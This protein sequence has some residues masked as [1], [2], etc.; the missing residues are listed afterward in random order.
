MITDAAAVPKNGILIG[1]DEYIEKII[2]SPIGV[3][4]T[5][6]LIR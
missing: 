1:N 6:I 3:L 5:S 4:W 2:F